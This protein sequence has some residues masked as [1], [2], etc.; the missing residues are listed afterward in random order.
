MVEAPTSAK[1]RRRRTRPGMVHTRRRNGDTARPLRRRVGAE[2]REAL[3]AREAPD[4][5]RR[6]ERNRA[7][8]S[9]AGS[10]LCGRT[11]SPQR[12]AHRPPFQHRAIQGR[13]TRGRRDC[14]ASPSAQGRRRADPRTAAPDHGRRPERLL[15][16]LW[17][18]VSGRCGDGLP[19]GHHLHAGRGARII[20]PSVRASD[21]KATSAS[22]RELGTPKAIPTADSR[23]GDRQ[24]TGKP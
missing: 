11:S 10:T 1:V 12:A 2:D 24:R 22:R 5:D 17:R 14:G 21:A 20:T 4:P 15:T 9:G 19:K 8:H 3:S 23:V 18:G 13:G 7:A 6:H 16:A